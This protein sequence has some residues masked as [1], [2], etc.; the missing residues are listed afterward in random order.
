M[1]HAVRRSA[2]AATKPAAATLH[3]TAPLSVSERVANGEYVGFTSN[4]LESDVTR[5][6]LVDSRVGCAVDVHDARSRDFHLARDGFELRRW[7]SGVSDFKDTAAVIRDYVPEMRSL[8]QQAVGGTSTV[9]VWDMCLRDST[10][11]NELQTA[12]AAHDS[13]S[14]PLDTLAPVPIVHIDFYSPSNVY[15]RLRQRCETPTDTL[16]SCMAADFIGAGL[17][18]TA[19]A[20][21]IATGGRVVSLNVWRSVDSSQPIRRDPLAMCEPRSVRASELIP[22]TI[23]CPDVELVEAHL[24]ADRAH[25]H[26]WW[27]AAGPT[28]HMHVHVT[29]LI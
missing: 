14:V 19:V 21:F 8:V 22:F 3:Y 13:T 29:S 16:S 20:D 23:C 7:P 9:I 24:T 5:P 12:S 28:S 10:L 17:S 2:I 15:E 1:R 4:P 25:A 26:R 18:P 27:C 6:R 11:D